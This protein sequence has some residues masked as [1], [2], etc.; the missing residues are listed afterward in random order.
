M[1][2]YTLIYF[3]INNIIYISSTPLINLYIYICM[4]VSCIHIVGI[5]P[6][7]TLFHWDT[8]QAFEDQFGG[9]LSPKIV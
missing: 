5:K 2:N 8:P 9:F 1:V 4:Y 3:Q 6:F 7:I